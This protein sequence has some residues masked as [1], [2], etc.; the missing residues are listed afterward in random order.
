M[1]WR[2]D[3]LQQLA[4]QVEE[5]AICRKGEWRGRGLR[6]PYPR[7]HCKEREKGRGGVN[8]SGVSELNKIIRCF[9]GHMTQ[10]KLS[11]VEKNQDET[12]TSLSAA[13][14]CACVCVC[15]LALIGRYRSAKVASF[16]FHVPL[17]PLPRCPVQF[18]FIPA[19]HH[20]WLLGT[21]RRPGT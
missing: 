15:A 2:R 9:N 16:M 21:T 19:L 13:S 5:E 14:V 7:Y 3:S 1:G 11:I 8:Q 12:R 6:S 10:V 17:P 4:S 18:K 20:V